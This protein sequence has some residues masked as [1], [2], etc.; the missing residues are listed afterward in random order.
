MAKK[1][2]DA[3]YNRSIRYKKVRYMKKLTFISLAVAL[4]IC[5]V[6]SIVP[7]PDPATEGMTGVVT[8]VFGVPFPVATQTSHA[9]PDGG[10]ESEFYPFGFVANLVVTY[11]AV[12]IVVTVIHIWKTKRRQ[13]GK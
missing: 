3:C 11:L 13:K 8:T 10:T 9:V 4:V 6:L 7:I 12:L 1:Q 2:Q 5:G